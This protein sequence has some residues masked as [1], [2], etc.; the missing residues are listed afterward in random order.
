MKICKSTYQWKCLK[1]FMS[2]LDYGSKLLNKFF[3]LNIKDKVL[4]HLRA[5][6]KETAMIKIYNNFFFWGGGETMLSV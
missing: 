3:F 1:K 5:K 4:L 2:F 6:S